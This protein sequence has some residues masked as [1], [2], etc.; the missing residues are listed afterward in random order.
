MQDVEATNFMLCW[1]YF[2]EEVRSCHCRAQSRIVCVCVYLYKCLRMCLCVHVPMCGDVCV[3]AFT[4]VYAH[5]MCVWAC[6][7]FIHIST[8]TCVCAYVCACTMHIHVPV[9]VHVPVCMHMP[10]HACMYIPLSLCVCVC[11]CLCI[12]MCL[13]MGWVECW[14]TMEDIKILKRLTTHAITISKLEGILELLYP[15]H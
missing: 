2:N 6:A 3:C 12:F 14:V 5:I 1:P 13:C 11:E 8:Y 4:S 10:V 7:M 9:C 15:I